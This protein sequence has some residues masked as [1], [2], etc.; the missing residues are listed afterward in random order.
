MK[1]RLEDINGQ[2][3]AIDKVFAD[4]DVRKKVFVAFGAPG[5]GTTWTLNRCAER[6]E[7]EGGAAL[8]AKGEESVSERRL[9]PWLTMALPGAK[10]LA[11]LEVLKG[12]LAHGSRAVPLVGS[13]TSYLVEEVLNHRKRRLAREALVLTEQEQDLLFVIQAT[14]QRKRLLLTLDHPEVW[15]GASWSLLALIL[16][17]RLDELYPAL[18]DAVILVGASKETPA[19][20]RSI[21]TPERLTELPIRLLEHDQLPVAL[22]TFGLGALNRTDVALLYEITNGRLDLLHDIGQHFRESDLTGFSAGWS[23]FYTRLVKRRLL[24]LR[25]HLRELEDTLTAAA[26]IGRTFTLGDIACLTGFAIDSVTAT[27]RLATSEHFVSSIGD[28]TRFESAELHRYFHRAGEGEHARYHAK[29]AECLRAMRPGDYGHR[30]HHLRLAGNIEDAQTCYA[31]AALAA[32]REY[33]PPPDPGDLEASLGW[34][35]IRR[36][37]DAMLSAFEAY[38]DQQISN[39]LSILD[40]LETFLPDVLIAERD[41]LEAMLLLAAPSV[42][43]YDRARALLEQWNRLEGREGELWTRI[44]QS[45]IVA[46]VQ[47]GHI[48]EA[49]R[50]EAEITANYWRRRHVDP[51]AI[52]ALN[53]LRRRSECLHSLPTATQR[54]EDALAYFGPAVPRSLPRHPIQYYYTLTNLIGNQ[55]ASGHFGYASMRST[56]LEELIRSYPYIPWPVPEIAANNSVLARYLDGI[57]DVATATGLLTQ[58][59]RD[60]TESGDR[61]LLQNNCAVLL[62]HAGRVQEA[63]AILDVNYASVVKSKEPD[64]YHRYFVGTNLAALLALDGEIQRALNLIDECAASISQFYPAIHATII[65]RHQLFDEAIKEAPTLT[66]EEFDNFLLQRYGMQVGPQW[67]FYG[68]GFLLTDIQFWSAD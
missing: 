19:R 9:F 5:A 33:R 38:E 49:R 11:R 20:I 29:F 40:G 14:A 61:I 44:A 58:L 45:L 55:L 57:L 64:G 15:D 25:E 2:Q 35:E 39:G 43:G 1:K 46:Q 48:E 47:T 30:V 32:R 4:R 62:I 65:R 27:L 68:R 66:P 34:N 60:S 12:T 23:D 3:T 18:A 54:L 13:V 10:R 28:M 37:L 31:L 42:D 50:L 16:S 53:V 7:S 67:A 56:E 63:R 6:W 59:T 24:G 26:V 8:E 17:E 41:Y 21:V 36:Y 52:H 22:T 51:W